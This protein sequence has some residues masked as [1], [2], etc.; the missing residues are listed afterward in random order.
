MLLCY[1]ISLCPCNFSPFKSEA[2]LILFSCSNFSRMGSFSLSSSAGSCF[3]SRDSSLALHRARRRLSLCILVLPPTRR[4]VLRSTLPLLD[5]DCLVMRSSARSGRPSRFL[6]EALISALALRR[7]GFP[8]FD[9]SLRP[10]NPF[11]GED[12]SVH[13]SVVH[14]GLQFCAA[15]R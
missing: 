7:S 3:S 13:F 6:L 15:Q 5:C 2:R 9:F 1:S 8:A 12:F 14:S 4:S 11:P 10:P